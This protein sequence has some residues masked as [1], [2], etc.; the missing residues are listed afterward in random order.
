MTVGNSRYARDAESDAVGAS[1]KS[2]KGRRRGPRAKR[3]WLTALLITTSLCLSVVG[4]IAWLAAK[5][6]T[7]RTQLEAATDQIPN[8]EAS[9]ANNDSVEAISVVSKMQTHTAEAR[10]AVGD[11]LWTLASAVPGIGPNFSAVGEVARTAD[12][13]TA[14]GMA[15]LVR[16]Y[17]S[18]DW[19]T[20]V[21]TRTGTDLTALRDAA[22][23]VSS[24]ARAVRLSAQRLNEI[25]VT[26][27]LPEVADPL[28]RTRVQLSEA[29]IMLDSAASAAEIL[30]TMLGAETP[31]SY[32][33]MIQN[34][35]ES[36]S[37]GGIP[38][39]LAVLNLDRGK[40][41]LGLQSSATA[42]GTMSP[43][44]PLDEEQH[45]IYSGRLGKYMQDVNL[46][47]DF[48]SA[49]KLAQQ[50]WESKTNSKVDGVI[51]ID[52][53]ALGYILDATGPV[54]IKDPELLIM[55]TNSGLPSELSETN[56]V[57]TLLS[58]VYAKI[59]QPQLQDAYYAG[60][61][62]EV[63][64]ALS[65][66]QSNAQE[67]VRSITRAAEERRVLVWSA[68][69]DEQE[70]ISAYPVG[71]AVTGASVSPAQFGV[72]FNDGTGAKM[73][74][75]VKRTVQLL[76]ECPKDG[77][78]QA[79]VRITSTNTAPT[80]AASSLPGYVTGDGVFGVPPGS[81]QTN[82]VTYGPVQSNVETAKLD[83]QRTEFAPYI[84]SNRP[85]GVLSIR[86]APGESKTIEF[87]YGK[88]VQHA[89]PNVVVTP[90][91]QAVNDVTLPTEYASCS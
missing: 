14:I 11:P 5:A 40:L 46:T 82:V 26:E 80:D 61:A 51:S 76:K 86:L 4:S 65:G 6:N 47:P 18:L 72:Y 90:T 25:D 27:L 81:V 8:L 50:M 34:N 84:H 64:N 43:T 24:S 2:S 68:H 7:I 48:P 91:V 29:T 54:A 59:E 22:P 13:V 78:E 52:P 60:V 1:S 56:V 75:Y 62:Q 49:A 21:P 9:I 41:T 35:A 16:V 20:L 33:L 74:Y 77:Y 83:G 42:L 55:A 39:A 17:K 70:T 85:V 30:P 73:D 32:L 45:R 66:G 58:D 23:A 63:F 19:N 38:G 57:P 87:T 28:V 53:I 15:P 10:K 88:I 12:D 67:L 79:T 36:R 37:S 89:E 3:R 69:S 44:L 71:G 31:R